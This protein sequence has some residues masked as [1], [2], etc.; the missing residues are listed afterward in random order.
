MCKMLYRYFLSSIHISILFL[1][2]SPYPVSI[3]PL[4]SPTLQRRITAIHSEFLSDPPPEYY[5]IG[6]TV[7]DIY[8]V[9]GVALKTID[10]DEA[11]GGI[12]LSAQ[13][14]YSPNDEEYPPITS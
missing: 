2:S 13:P 4:L 5:T 6:A 9:Y 1:S 3:L 8:L 7:A 14:L 11:S 10:A 12:V